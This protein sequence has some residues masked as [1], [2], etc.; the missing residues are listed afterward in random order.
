MKFLTFFIFLWA[1]SFAGQVQASNVRTGVEF[2][3]VRCGLFGALKTSIRGERRTLTVSKNGLS[4]K[5]ARSALLQEINK[6]G[7]RFEAD[8][9]QTKEI[10]K[11]CERDDDGNENCATYRTTYRIYE[12]PNLRIN[13]M[14]FHGRAF[15]SRQRIR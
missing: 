5:T 15:I 3:K 14:G 13:K 10:N 9:Y 8:I 11:E 12:I 6:Q 2:T 7:N 4:C 1:F